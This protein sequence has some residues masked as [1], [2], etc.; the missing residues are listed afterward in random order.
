M[1]PAF[2]TV[3]CPEWPLD[4]V[5][6]VAESVGALGVELRTFGNGSTEFACDP[7]LTG[8]D[9]LRQLFD[10][11]GV[12]PCCLATSVRF[13]EPIDPPVLGRVL[14]HEQSVRDAKS[15]IDLARELEIPF[16]RV[17]GF[18]FHGDENR[19]TATARIVDRLGKAADHC[20]NTGVRLV[21]EN[22]GSFSTASSL[23]DLLDRVGNPLVSAA[24][25]V[26][27][28]AAAGEAPD[29][30]LNV[31]SD[32]LTIVKLKDFAN[33]NP[34]AL[35]SGNQPNVEALAAMA[36]V[37]FDGWTVYEHDRAW[38]STVPDGGK[39]FKLEEPA[40]V[41]R[42]SMKFLFDR[43]PKATSPMKTGGPALV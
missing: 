30:G 12:T 31:L 33:G 3:A 41:L 29:S 16:V 40:D 9:K 10:K 32:R 23:A 20:R 21:L 36:R 39:P 2:S 5:C 43:I 22:G 13:D 17:F 11:A 34:T 1:K 28:A 27:V 25:S 7:A 6:E 26:S 24:Y 14:D 15:A 18:E 8:A 37:G 42:R 35:G 19:A 38:L 4:R